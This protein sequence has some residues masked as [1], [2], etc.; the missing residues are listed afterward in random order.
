MA[1][2]ELTFD[3]IEDFFFF[4]KSKVSFSLFLDFWR[5]LLGGLCGFSM[6]SP[7]VFCDGWADGRNMK[8]PT[9]KNLRWWMNKTEILFFF[10]WD[11]AL[12]TCLWVPRVWLGCAPRGTAD[13]E[14]GAEMSPISSG[15]RRPCFLRRDYFSVFFWANQCQIINLWISTGWCK[16][17]SF[18]TN[19]SQIYLQISKFRP[20]LLQCTFFSNCIWFFCLPGGFAYATSF[21]P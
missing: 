16:M 6:P 21:F 19:Q 7:V 12:A 15:P 8:F 11:W 14:R 1:D 9:P 5:L 13:S 20:P 4:L 17:G 18:Y 2:L 10:Q 3:S